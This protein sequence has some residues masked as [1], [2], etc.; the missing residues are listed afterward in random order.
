MGPST[1]TGDREN[2][3]TRIGGGDGMHVRP[4]PKNSSIVYVGSQYGNYGRRDLDKGEYSRITPGHKLG[5]P[6]YRYNW[7]SPINLSSHNPEIVY[8]GSQRLNRS[9]DEGKTWTAI[10]PDL[11]NDHW[12]GDVPYSTISTIAESPLDFGVI[13]VGTDDGNI[14]VTKD[15]G[16][17]WTQVD[18]NLPQDRWVSEVHASKYDK[19]TAYASLNGYR[20]DEFTTYLYKTTDYGQTWTSVKGDLPE[21][22]VNV[23]VQDPVNPEILYA[24]LDHGA[25]VSFNDGK[26]WHYLTGMPNVATYDM[27]VHP[28]DLE[29]VIATHGRSMWVM[30]VKP[31]HAV[32]DRLDER[33]TAFTPE[34]IRYSGRWGSSFSV[35]REPF[36]PEVELMYFLGADGDEQEVTIEVKNDKG[37]VVTE[38]ST[39][40]N[41]GFNTY[42]W[43][44][45]TGENDGQYQFLSRGKYTLEFNTR[46]GSHSVEFEIE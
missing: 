46:R 43:N 41:Q 24:G 25:Y 31:L 36:M 18:G 5:E 16:A 45:V 9:M 11:T 3:W 29:L 39:A 26:N 27:L 13:W 1:S 2:P 44:L 14:H 32:A 7:N 4:N 20:W 19:A 34:S 12:N 22:V 8:F 42:A 35:F 17:A 37:E 6:R 40:G 15:G 30:D 38:I 21:D 10:S 28:R 23:I 33:I